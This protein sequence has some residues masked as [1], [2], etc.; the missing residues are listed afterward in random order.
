LTADQPAPGS[1]PLAPAERQAI[2]TRL[3]DFL[4]AGRVQ[5]CENVA[6]TAVELARRF[7]PELTRQAEIAGLVHDSAKK[8][9]DEQLIELAR[10]FDIDITPGERETPQL[11]HGKVGSALLPE[12]FGIDDPEVRTAVTDH[13]CGRAEM[14]LLSQLLFVADQIAAGRDFPGVADV[15][16]V[17]RRDLQAAVGWVARKKIEHVLGQGQWIEPATV[18][19]W[20]RFRQLQDAN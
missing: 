20:N 16:E 10:R 12:R 6:D 1:A 8:L 5:H 19:V 9:R 2:V 17:A 3:H 7:A 13:V 14:G 4:G 11:L 18:D 15:R